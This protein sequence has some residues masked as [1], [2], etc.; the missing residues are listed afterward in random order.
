[1]LKESQRRYMRYTLKRERVMR[2]GGTSLGLSYTMSSFPSVSLRFTSF[3]NSVS[4]IIQRVGVK[5]DMLRR[6][7]LSASL[8][9]GRAP[10]EQGQPR[11]QRKR[12]RHWKVSTER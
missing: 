9:D 4:E 12:T 5:S 6:K 1:M 8:R 10:P 11:Q 3:A 7:V 2:E